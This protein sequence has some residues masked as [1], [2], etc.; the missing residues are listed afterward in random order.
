MRPEDVERYRGRW[1]A[2]QRSDDVV[3]ADAESLESLQ[4][5]LQAAEHPQVLIRRIPA[6]DDPVFV[7][8]G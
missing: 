8:L 6:L 5:S 1:V 2:L 3:V 4:E 7:G